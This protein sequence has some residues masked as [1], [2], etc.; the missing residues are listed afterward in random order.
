[1][2]IDF[3]NNVRDTFF[4]NKRP[5]VAGRAISITFSYVSWIE[6]IEH[7]FFPGSLKSIL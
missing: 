5:K 6:A 7:G 2:E 3:N 4:L 1:M